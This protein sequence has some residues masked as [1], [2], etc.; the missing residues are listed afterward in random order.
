MKEVEPNEKPIRIFFLEPTDKS[1]Y[2]TVNGSSQYDNEQLNLL[3]STDRDLAVADGFK[4]YCEMLTWFSNTYGKEMLRPN[5]FMII[6][7]KP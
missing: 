4:T 6:R 2:V 5:E 7:W 3:Y 1:D